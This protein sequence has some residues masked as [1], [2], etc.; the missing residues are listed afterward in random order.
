MPAQGLRP[1]STHSSPPHHSKRIEAIEARLQWCR[2]LA[3]LMLGIGVGAWAFS[4]VKAEST[5]LS[6]AVFTIAML[7]CLV[8][9]GAGAML[10][11]KRDRLRQH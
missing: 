11:S 2:W 3:A 10:E 9:M 4:N 1:S 6:L 5:S 8:A 7:V